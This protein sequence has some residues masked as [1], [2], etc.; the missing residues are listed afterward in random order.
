MATNWLQL[1]SKLTF[2]KELRLHNALLEIPPPLL[3]LITRS[4]HLAILDLSGNYLDRPLTLLPWFSNFS[5]FLTSI[6]FSWN[7]IQG[8]IPHV[9]QDMVSLKHLDLSGNNLQGG[10][11]KFFGNMSN[12]VHLDLNKNNLMGEFPQLVMNLSGPTQEKLEY[13]DLSGNSVSGSFSNISKFSSLRELKLRENLLNGTIP[14][15]FLQLPYLLVLDLSSNQLTGPVPDLSLSSSLKQ[16]SLDNNMF[17]EISLESFGCLS[18]LEDLWIGSNLLEDLKEAHM[19]N[20]SRLRILDLSLNSFLTLKFNPHRVPPFQL[21][22]LSLR[23]CKLEQQFPLCLKTQRQIVYIDISNVGI[24]DIIPSWFGSIAPRLMYMNASSNQMYGAFPNF[25]FS[26]T[27]SFKGSSLSHF[28]PIGTILDLSRNKISDNHFSG[29]IPALFGSLRSLSL[30]HLRNNNFSGEVP[31]SMGNC[32][33]LRMIDLGENKLTGKI[34]A[35]IGHDY[36]QLQVLILRSNEF[37]DKVPSSLCKLACIQILDLSSNRISGAIPEC[38]DNWNAMTGDIYYRPPTIMMGYK[39]PVGGRFYTLNYSYL[40]SSYFMWKGKEVKHT[41]GLVNLIDL[42]NNNL[43][44]KIPSVI[45]KLVSL[46]GLNFSRNNLTGSILP[47]IGQLKELNFLD[48]SRNQLSG[49]VPTSLSDLSS[50]GVLNLSYNNLSGRIPQSKQ[51]LTFDELAYLGNSGLCG[52]PLNKSCPGDEA[53]QNPSSSSDLNNAKNKGEPED[54]TIITEGFYIAMGLGFIVGFWGIFGSVLFNKELRCAL[55][56]GF[57]SLTDFVYIRME[58][59]KAYLLR[60]F[61]N[62]LALIKLPIMFRLSF[63]NT[64]IR[65]SCMQVISPA[66]APRNYLSS[67]SH[68]VG[69]LSYLGNFVIFLFSSPHGNFRKPLYS[70]HRNSHKVALLAG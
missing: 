66:A 4:A 1:I 15:G 12:L 22:Y 9:F 70:S 61:Q 31:T 48:F 57:D 19:F 34:P 7:G 25:S 5:S 55:F 40:E 46:V 59:S 45:T 14:E 53:R 10:I 6:D 62:Q 24:S 50:L 26:T 18:K 13:L 27:I 69:C 44:G 56:K 54:D 29:R 42:S 41:K 38:V 37:H 30:L 68:L 2:I 32:T 47:S 58:L 39:F 28:H 43:E 16:L 20:L 51:A 3:P 60:H 11:P 23:E 35:W 63:S 65:A 67:R 8:P 52:K 64:N 17:K 49:S 33:M 21:E 36:S